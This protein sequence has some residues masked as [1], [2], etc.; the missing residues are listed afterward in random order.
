MGEAKRRTGQGAP[1]PKKRRAGSMWPLAIGLLV[2]VLILGGLLYWLTNPS[3]S[4]IDD[5][6][7]AEQGA[8]PFP[9]ELDRF[10]VSLG[11]ANAPVVVREFADYQC[12]GCASFAEVVQ[13]LKKEYIEPGKVRLV[14]FDF[15]L[16]QHR[17]AMPA[18][19]AA[20]CAR[21]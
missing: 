15:P 13:R 3:L 11:D 9:A 8:A 17:N 18:A 1:H 14:Y 16:S 20:R 2:V 4:P 5:L 10:G 7:Q 12:P 19:Q 6:P 21:P